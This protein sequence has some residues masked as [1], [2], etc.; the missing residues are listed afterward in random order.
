[1]SNGIPWW[2]GQEKISV[3]KNVWLICFLN[4]W[5]GA[6]KAVLNDN[7]VII[8]DWVNNVITVSGI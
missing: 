4:L 2:E 1:M 3:S 7:K 6:V 5:D 8:S